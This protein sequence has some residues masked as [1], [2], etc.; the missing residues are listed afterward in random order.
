MLTAFQ[1]MVACAGKIPLYLSFGDDQSGT[2]WDIGL[3]LIVYLLMSSFAYL[4]I[5][6]R[7]PKNKIYEK[8]EIVLFSF[9]PVLYPAF[10]I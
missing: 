2:K 5:L 8:M 10:K 4:C 3:Q 6:M 9:Q 7:M 1:A